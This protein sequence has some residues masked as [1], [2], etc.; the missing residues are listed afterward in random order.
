M[1][2]YRRVYD[3]H[4]MQADCQEPGSAGREAE[5]CDEH[6]CL[7]VCLSVRSRVSEPTVS[8]GG[9]SAVGLDSRH[10]TGRQSGPTTDTE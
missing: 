5:Y 8:A 2:A 9:M 3:S 10:P 4:Q 1:A 6:V 7:S